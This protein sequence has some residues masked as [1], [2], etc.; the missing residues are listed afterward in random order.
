MWWRLAKALAVAEEDH[1]APLNPW[2]V[3]GWAILAG[4]L[5]VGAGAVLCLPRFFRRF[6]GLGP[7]MVFSWVFVSLVSQGAFTGL[8]PALYDTMRDLDSWRS[9]DTR[10]D[11]A[12][13]AARM[14]RLLVDV[15]S[16]SPGAVV[17]ARP[18]FAGKGRKGGRLGLRAGGA[19]VPVKGREPDTWQVLESWLAGRMTRLKAGA[20]G[21]AFKASE[22]IV[23]EIRM[24]DTRSLFSLT[25]STPKPTGRFTRPRTA[26]DAAT[27]AQVAGLARVLD[28]KN[29]P[30][31]P[32]GVATLPCSAGKATVYSASDDLSEAVSSAL[33]V[34]G[35]AALTTPDGRRGT[36]THI[37]DFGARVAVGTM[38]G[39]HVGVRQ[40]EI[41]SVF[42]RCR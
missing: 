34:R 42:Q 14:D 1:P 23:V 31:V 18:A 30:A 33:L 11:P 4:G 10:T 21:T 5:T 3:L 13:L 17:F 20:G 26:R 2:L 24:D 9:G 37:T 25:I 7:L 28:P 39:L 22:D 36:L 16:A 6:P 40:G 27:A 19:I 12:V 29:R 15:L 8:H 38:D 41:V 32:E 35:G